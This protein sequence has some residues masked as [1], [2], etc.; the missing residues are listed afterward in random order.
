MKTINVRIEDQLKAQAE[1][2]LARHGV[3]PTEAVNHLYLYLAQHGQLPFRVSKRAEA[4]A[5]VF[6]DTLI[7]VRLAIDALQSVSA[8][9]DGA[10]D[11]D[12]LATQCRLRCGQLRQDIA[13]SAAFMALAACRDPLPRDP[14]EDTGLYWQWMQ[15]HL[16]QAED[17]LEEAAGNMSALL[18]AMTGQ[19][20]AVYWQLA[21]FI[22][23]YGP[24]D[25]GP[26]RPSRQTGNSSKA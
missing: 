22:D 15:D 24:V 2:V 26:F 14:D 11:R 5:D 6:R 13:G 25:T 10:P 19:I 8:M 16:A 4:P 23:L 20:N 17:V 3:S 7:R 21:T 12:Y 1:E 18:S 9:P